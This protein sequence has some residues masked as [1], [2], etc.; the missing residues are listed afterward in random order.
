MDTCCRSP[1]GTA[2]HRHKLFYLAPLICLAAGS[3]CML[4]AVTDMISK[5][6]FFDPAKRRSDS[7]YLRDNV[8]AVSVCVHHPGEST[9]L[10]L[11]S[12]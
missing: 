11:N 7:R 4:N 12:H 6:F 8:D 5:D 9:D 1:I 2:N 3:N 10:T